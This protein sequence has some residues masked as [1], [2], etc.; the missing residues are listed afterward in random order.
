MVDY[1]IGRERFTRNSTPSAALVAVR[2]MTSKR[3]GLSKGTARALLAQVK[4][5]SPKMV[6]AD[7]LVREASLFLAPF[8]SWVVFG[9]GGRS[10][11]PI[12]LDGGPLGGIAGGGGFLAAGH[13]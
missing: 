1:N 3:L 11:I 5:Q 2:V 7:E 12:H 6:E 10:Q 13:D 4:R 9:G 8:L